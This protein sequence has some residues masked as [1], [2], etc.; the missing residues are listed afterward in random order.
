MEGV[1]PSSFSYPLKQLRSAGLTGE[2]GGL[3]TVPKGN[4]VCHAPIARHGIGA[5]LRTSLKSISC[6]IWRVRLDRAAK[7]EEKT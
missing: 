3:M 1:D 6:D 7:S 5:N 2:G 4:R